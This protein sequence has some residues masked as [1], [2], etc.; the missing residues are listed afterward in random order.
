MPDGVRELYRLG[1]DLTSAHGAPFSGI[2]FTDG[3]HTVDGRFPRGRGIGVRRPVLHAL[4]AE[5]A[6]RAGADLRWGVAGDPLDAHRVRVGRDVVPTRWI[7][8]ADGQ[9]SPV[10][11]RVGLDAVRGR[12]HRYAVRGHYQ[13]RP[14]SE[15]VEVHWRPRGQFYVTPV[16]PE[17]V[18]LVFVSRT[19][20]RGLAS[21]LDDCPQ[22]AARLAG[23]RATSRARGALSTSAA[24]RRVAAGSVALVGDASGSVDA[25]SGEGLS[26]A[27]QQAGALAAAL[28]SDD[29][30][31]YRRAHR[32]LARRP[33][34]MAALML[35]M[36]RWP[37]FGR[38]ALPALARTPTL[39]RELLALH[40]G[41]RPA[42]RI[43][44]PEAIRLGSRLLV[45]SPADVSAIR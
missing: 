4:L 41:A 6:A 36:D 13:I 39:F 3:D 31:A 45:S 32:R 42:A 24:L 28:E 43:L 9:Q 26:L 19:P 16:G 12:S 10:R 11:R 22:L 17:E 20:I 18:C 33:R 15:F 14:W 21:A 34:W 40:V 1:V 23:V 5:R 44:I 27:F 29:L 2:R 25:V 8:G 7:V 35:T 30:A 37:R 38:Q